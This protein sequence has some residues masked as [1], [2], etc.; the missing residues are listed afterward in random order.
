M[1]YYK[2]IRR[3]NMR[4]SEIA[5]YV[6]EKYPDCSMANNND[7]KIGHR[8][9]SYEE[10]LID[11]LMDFFSFDLLHMCGC[12]HP[13]YTHE[14]IRKVLLIQYEW[15]E[16]VISY[17]EAMMRYK[18]ELGLDYKNENHDG[19]LEFVLYS[20]DTNGIVEHGGSICSC[21]LTDLGKMYLTVLNIWH[22]T[23]E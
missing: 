6:V 7:I 16:D 22:D 8:E 9:D 3:E 20:L 15:Q 11:P 12:G 1:R 13:D 5:K 21:W 14:I 19:F 2:I 23:K 10:S 18:D 17:D 4:L